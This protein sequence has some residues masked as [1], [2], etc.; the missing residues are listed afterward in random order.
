[1]YVATGCV[2]CHTMQGIGGN[3]GPDLTQLGTRF[4]PEDILESIIEPSQVISSQYSATVFYLDNGQSVVGRL[5]KEDEQEYH[6]SQ[7]PFAPDI[8]RKIPKDQV[9]DTK[10]SQV[11]MMPPGL[12]N[13]L[14]EEELKDLL[15]Y[16]ISGGDPNHEVFS[17]ATEEKTAQ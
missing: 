12:I 8:I 14:N 1:M 2:S 11:S 7:N 4:S 10:I 5:I 15:A 17:E 9:T 6:I 3:V 16:L 13:R